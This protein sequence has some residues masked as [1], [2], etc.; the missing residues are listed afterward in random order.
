MSNTK[1]F[2]QSELIHLALIGLDTQIAEL[3]E[4]RAQL[5][6]LTNQQSA[7]PTVKAAAPQQKGGKISDAARAKISAA[8]KARWAKVKKAQTEAAK[9]APNAKKVQSKNI[10]LKA[11]VVPAKAKKAPAKKDQSKSSTSA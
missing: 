8:A 1:P 10:S 6:A 5:A 3:Q 9:T 11:Q 7:G 2:D 4:K